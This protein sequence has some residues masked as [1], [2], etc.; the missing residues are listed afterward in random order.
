METI[1]QET[2][3]TE[4]EQVILDHFY[5]QEGHL[6]SILRKGV[7]QE[8][9]LF[10]HEGSQ[11]N[12][13]YSAFIDLDGGY[14]TNNFNWD[15]DYPIWIYGISHIDEDLNSLNWWL[16]NSCPDSEYV[17]SYT[18]E[19]VY[20]ITKRES[21]FYEHLY[22]YSEDVVWTFRRIMDKVG[23]NH[24]S[25][26]LDDLYEKRLLS[27]P[28]EYL[29]RDV[30]RGHF[31][32]PIRQRNWCYDYLHNVRLTDVPMTKNLLKRHDDDEIFLD[33]EK[34][35]FKNITP[36]FED[37]DALRER[38]RFTHIPYPYR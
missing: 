31:S 3:L 10:L 21:D 15:C 2:N 12:S 8:L 30:S 11:K 19:D 13:S 24:L 26:L 37:W 14:G 27:L 38:F 32:D 22:N 28:S 18:G 17:D 35:D 9:S 7:Q 6:N 5:G 4:T 34:V 16:K 25:G 36:V 33:K 29:M 1:K 23:A 20:G